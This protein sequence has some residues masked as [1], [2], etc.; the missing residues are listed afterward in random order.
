MMMLLEL[1]LLLNLV[2]ESLVVALLKMLR[3]LVHICQ[4][5]KWM[6]LISDIDLVLLR[7]IFL[8]LIV[9]V[10][11][12]IELLLQ[13]ADLLLHCLCLLLLRQVINYSNN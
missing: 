11:N 3:N 4:L 2:F 12:Q 10:K 8:I 7:L 5:I 9:E 1:N 6:I 13:Y